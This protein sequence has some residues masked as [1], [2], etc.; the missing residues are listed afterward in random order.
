MVPL[1]SVDAVIFAAKSEL[2]R[3]VEQPSQLTD[4]LD[5]VKVEFRIERVLPCSVEKDI[6]PLLHIGALNVEKNTVLPCVV[7]KNSVFAFI[8]E[9][10]T[11]DIVMVHPCAVE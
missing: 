11:V 2:P 7:E 1:Y 3:I 6:S 8:D 9:A 5:P 4:K 10:L